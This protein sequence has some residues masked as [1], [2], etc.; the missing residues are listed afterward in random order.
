MR[1][2]FLLGNP[3]TKRTDYLKKAAAQTGISID[4]LNWKDWSGHLPEGEIFLKID[5]PLWDSC[6][7]E[8]LEPLTEVY[9]RQLAE[10]GQAA[11]YR[12]VEF[13]NTP[14]VIAELL[15][16]YGC[17][18]CLM[19]AGLPVTDLLC[20]EDDVLSEKVFFCSDK[21]KC[22]YGVMQT[23]PENRYSDGQ[24]MGSN[25]SLRA[26]VCK[27]SQKRIRSTEQLLEE[28]SQRRVWQVFIKP[29]FGS[30]AAGVS[31][32]RVQPGTG[33]MSLYTCA[34]DV[35]D[36]GLVNTKRLRQYT[37]PGEVRRLLDRLLGLDCVVERW[38]PKAAYDRYVYDLRVVVQ[39][40][41]IDYILARLSKGPITN[42]HLNNHPLSIEELGLPFQTMVGV[43][44]LC[45]RAMDCFSGL[46]SAGIDILLEKGSLKPRIIEMNAQGDLIYQDIYHENVIYR[47]QAERMK[48]WMG[49]FQ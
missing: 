49:E 16:K 27:D 11:E 23:L 8:Q 18:K 29:V 28:M 15:D 21:Q 13:F 2:V 4:F 6:S 3:S 42:L 5:P 43:E 1:Q 9:R 17:K 46:K 44:E 20:K 12:K 26:D 24:K 48:S 10:I 34:F 38:Y 45:Q 14:S 22:Q 33:R 47:R 37:E 40:H 39:E 35:P 19:R 25:S 30:G 31:G 41:K 7:L 36:S 32:F